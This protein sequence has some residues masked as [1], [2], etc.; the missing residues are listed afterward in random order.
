MRTR[1]WQSTPFLSLLIFL[2]KIPR[3][4]VFEHEYVFL[5]TLSADLFYFEADEC[6]L[7]NRDNEGFIYF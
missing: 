6:S 1:N 2:C 3:N 4:F 5:E 7:V